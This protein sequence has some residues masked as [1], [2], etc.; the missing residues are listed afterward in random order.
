MVDRDTRYH[1]G[2]FWRIL[3]VTTKVLGRLNA[4]A[5]KILVCLIAQLVGQRLDTKRGDAESSTNLSLLALFSL[6]DHD[7]IQVQNKTENNNF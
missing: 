5:A 2:I 3:V 4:P 1:S 7:H 6:R